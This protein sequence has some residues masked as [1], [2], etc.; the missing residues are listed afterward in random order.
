MNSIFPSYILN[1]MDFKFNYYMYLQFSKLCKR[2]VILFHAAVIIF[3][4]L[5]FFWRA[6]FAFLHK[7]LL[8]FVK[9]QACSLF[10]TVSHCCDF[11]LEFDIFNWIFTYSS[12]LWFVNTI[13]VYFLNVIQ[14]LFKLRK[15]LYECY[16]CPHIIRNISIKCLIIYSRLMGLK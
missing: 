3:K 5:K 11:N 4:Q 9:L 15:L 8:S 13:Y 16:F 1:H 7:K 12:V 10:F 6:C 14:H 2:S